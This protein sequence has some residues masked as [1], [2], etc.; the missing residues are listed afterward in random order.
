[1]KSYRDSAAYKRS[2]KL[3]PDGRPKWPLTT[4]DIPSLPEAH[5][6]VGRRAAERRLNRL[7]KASGMTS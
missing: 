5:E 4:E 2:N 7:T 3:R 6:A 1:M